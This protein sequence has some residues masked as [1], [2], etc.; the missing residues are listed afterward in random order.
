MPLQF[1]KFLRKVEV[2]VV[3]S[4]VSYQSEAVDK[5]KLS[6]EYVEKSA[7][8]YVTEE[9]AK[10]NG[11]KSGSIVKVT[12]GGK[13]VNLKLLISDAAPEDGAL[14]PNSI[15]SSYLSD[16]ENFKKFKATIELSD[17]EVTKPHE[18]ILKIKERG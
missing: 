12:S 6:Q 14:M 9:F 10:K 7:V 13:S 11:L 18:I 16:F 2:E 17:G 5:G 4:R 15:Y 1:A 3:V 8:I